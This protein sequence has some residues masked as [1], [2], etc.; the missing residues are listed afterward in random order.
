[1]RAVPALFLGLLALASCLAGA[2]CRDL[3]S[4]TTGSDRYEGAVVQGDFVRAG[5]DPSTTICLTLDT[6]HLQ[7]GPGALSTS[8]GRFH[9]AALRPIPQIWHDPLSTLSFGEGRLKNLVY[10]ASA[11]T[12]FSDGNGND[13]LAVV[14]LMQSGDVE[15]RLI[16]GAPGL[17]PDGGATTASGGNLFAVFDLVRQQG[18]CSY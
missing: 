18:P 17:A 7:D 13:V 5:V 9:T 8:D 14:S 1:M 16:R 3:S 6:D 2:G 15:V 11:T 4:F 12:P 10:V